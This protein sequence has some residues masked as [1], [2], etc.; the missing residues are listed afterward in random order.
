MH[1]GSGVRISGAMVRVRVEDQIQE[2]T[3][4]NNEVVCRKIRRFPES[5]GAVRCDF[6]DRVGT[7]LKCAAAVGHY[8]RGAR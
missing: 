3:Q 6:G 5:H 1:V 7:P 4:L 8:R 2:I